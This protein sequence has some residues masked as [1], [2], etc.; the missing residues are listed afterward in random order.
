[1]YMENNLSINFDNNEYLPNNLRKYIIKKFINIGSIKTQHP[2]FGNYKIA[3]T[4]GWGFPHS[5]TYKSWLHLIFKKQSF[6][7]PSIIVKK[8][9]LNKDK[10]KN[11]IGNERK[12]LKPDRGHSGQN[13]HIVH[14]YENVVKKINNNGYWILQKEIKPKLYQG[15]KFD[16]R[17][18]HFILQ[19]K[20]NWYNLI[21]SV[22]YAKVSSKQF[23]QNDD[24]INGFVTNITFN[25]NKGM[26][27]MFEFFDF[28]EKI[29]NN[30]EERKKLINNVYNLIRD[31]TKLMV[32]QLN[33]QNKMYFKDGKSISQ[34]MILGPDIIFDT[35][36]NTFLLETNSSPGILIVKELVYPL[37]KQMIDELIKNILVPI[38]K[39]ENINLDNY[40]GKTLTAERIY[41]D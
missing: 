21:S 24:N 3:S 6:Y 41:I 20:G 14:S 15:R 22:G 29:S 25:Q 28:M 34:I 33:E 19:H 1:M 30:D 26:Q 32:K 4:L 5:H 7:P 17:V 37:Q 18:F 39:E 2:D 27:V 40:K 23:N 9:F 12:I 16:T 10:I 8:N 36:G 35:H 13:I 31:Y 11:F 38:I